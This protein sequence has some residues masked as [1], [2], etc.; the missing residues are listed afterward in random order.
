MKRYVRI[1]RTMSAALV[2]TLLTALMMTGC[3]ASFDSV[4]VRASAT[5]RHGVMMLSGVLAQTGETSGE[6]SSF[7]EKEQPTLTEETKQLILQYRKN[8]TTE[9]YLTLRDKVVENYNTV[10]TKK[11]EKLEQ[12]KI[13][14]EGKPGGTAK[15]AEMEEIVQDMYITYWNH[16]NSSMLR[17]SDARLL[18]WNVSTASE[19]EYIPVMGA[20][21]SIYIKRTPVTNVEYAVFLEATG[22]KSPNGWTDGVYPE[23]EA[24]YPVNE[25]SYEDANA[26]CAWLTEQDGINTYRMPS[27][28][29]WELAAGHMP[30][31]ADFN[32]GVSDG[33]VSVEAYADV[34][35]GAHG[36]I[37]FWGNVWEWT[38]TQR[39]SANG[40]VFL[41]VKGGSWKSSR[42]E[43]RTEYR[44][45]S[46]NAALCYEDVGFRVI[47]V[48][49][50]EE[51]EQKADL[52]SLDA[53]AVTARTVSFDEVLLS[54]KAVDD[55]VEYQIFA[56]CQE[57]GLFVMLDRTVEN[58]FSV[59]DAD[60]I[61][62]YSYVV[63][64]LSYTKTSDNVAADYA[65][66]PDSDSADGAILGD[67][68]GDGA[69]NV[70]DAT[71]L[72][73]YLAKL[74]DDTEG[75]VGTCGDV[76]GDGAVDIVDATYIQRWL[77]K[78]VTNE[79]IGEIIEK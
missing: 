69:V 43:C 76:T 46:R 54:W 49:E 65:V 77:A 51:P 74:G 50:G 56:Y 59:S 11:E 57:T 72:Q 20:G 71:I 45:E 6:E 70:S 66:Q 8:P 30:K 1:P 15:V 10:L 19:Y 64:A 67:T 3:A 63:Q 23:D 37:D 32:C 9:N 36:A 21:E 34:T 48:L 27:E 41:G 79:K 14:T 35:R 58:T 22:Y 78:L 2:A 25:V 33:R 16:I 68:N 61:S 38:S 17:F 39:V 75:F 44:K 26:Y 42:T 24:D 62:G 47:Q 4:S 13:Q 73:R 55:A 18:K 28:S 40:E 53:P 29:E 5:A 31:D 52:C 7:V 12:L 60:R